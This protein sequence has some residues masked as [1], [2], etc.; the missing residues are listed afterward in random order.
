VPVFLFITG[1]ITVAEIFRYGI[2]THKIVFISLLFLAIGFIYYAYNDYFTQYYNSFNPAYRDDDFSDEVNRSSYLSMPLSLFAGFFGPFPTLLPG[3]DFEDVSVYAPTLILKV[4]ISP[5]FVVGVYFLWLK[6]NHFL[7][8]LA[9][10]CLFQITSLTLLDQTYKLR[11]AYLHI[12]FIIIISFYAINHLS[13]FFN[14]Y[15]FVRRVINFSYFLLAIFV[16]LWNYLR[17]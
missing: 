5:F 9:Y 13:K 10:F 16:F 4:F 6:R 12:P 11:Y 14:R 7:I 15:I 2:T 17:I 1:S 3:S 8:S